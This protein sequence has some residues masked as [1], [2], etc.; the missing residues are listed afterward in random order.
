MAAIWRPSKLVFD[1]T[2]APS[3]TTTE[4]PNAGDEN[5]DTAVSAG[6]NH[7]VLV[8]SDGTVFATGYNPYGQ[9]GDGTTVNRPTPVQVMTDVAAVSAGD[10][11]TVLLKSDGTVV[12]WGDPKFAG[13]PGSKQKDLVNIISLAS[14]EKA[15]AATKKD[16][17]IV[18]WGDE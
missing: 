9:L 18:V 11:H 6:T 13:D 16:G 8:K 14:N 3:P 2:P 12:V 4:A 17:S 7:A 15:F 1:P 5:D 10:S